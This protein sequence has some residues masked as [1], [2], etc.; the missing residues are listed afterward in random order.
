MDTALTFP[1]FFRRTFPAKTLHLEIDERYGAYITPSVAR[2]LE[3]AARCPTLDQAENV[4]MA[5]S[6]QMS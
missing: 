3:Q 1:R 5:P 2:A 4:L 6:A